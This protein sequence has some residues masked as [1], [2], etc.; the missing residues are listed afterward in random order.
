MGGPLQKSMLVG[1][2]GG[3]SLYLLF[4]HRSLIGL[5]NLI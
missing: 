1:A 5:T 4:L 2:G 3:D